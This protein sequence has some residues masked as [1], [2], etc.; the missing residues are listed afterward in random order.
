[1][2]EPIASTSQSNSNNMKSSNIIGSIAAS[3]LLVLLASLNASADIFSNLN[4]L[5][6]NINRV[7]NSTSTLDNIG[8][9]FG[10]GGSNQPADPSAQASGTQSND[11]KTKR[12]Y[13]GTGFSQREI[14]QTMGVSA[15]VNASNYKPYVEYK[16][17]GCSKIP[18]SKNIGMKQPRVRNVL[19]KERGSI[20]CSFSVVGS[21]DGF[22]EIK[23][24]PSNFISESSATDFRGNKVN[25]DTMVV[26]GDM[27][28]LRLPVKFTKNTSFALTTYLTYELP[29]KQ[30]TPFRS[31]TMK[32]DLQGD[33]TLKG[34]ILRD[35][36]LS[37]ENVNVDENITQ[38][39]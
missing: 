39:K 11:D 33:G 14:Y 34:K 4:N 16:L 32:F 25:M 5:N 8:K 3:T 26:N 15:P 24:S 29:S 2:T 6:R 38:K 9:M 12:V 7:N 13:V 36:S 18:N 10:I 20:V 22:M 28:S 19:Y 31:L 21:F 37:F 30:I 27:E 35:Q 1:M 23:G 17:I